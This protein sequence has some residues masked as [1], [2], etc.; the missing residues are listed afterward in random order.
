MVRD[1]HGNTAQVAPW[2]GRWMQLAIGI[3]CM[4]MIA[5]LQYGW[6]LFVEPIDDKHGWGRTAIQ[7]AFTIFIVTETWLV[8]VEGWFV[9]KFG[10]RI[11]VLVGGALC[12]LSW[13]LNAVADSLVLLYLAAVIGGIGAGGVYGTCVGNAL[14]WFPDRRGLAA[15]LTAAGF[16]A[17]S[18]LTVVP[19]ATM[20]ETSGFETTFMTFGLGQ[21]LVILVLAWFLVDPPKLGYGQARGGSAP[22]RRQYAP[23]EMLRTPVFWLM[24]GMF[25][26]VAAGGLM[27]TAQLGPIAADMGLV[28]APVSILGL[29]LPAL[30]FA[31]SIDRVMNGITRPFFGWVSDHI[32]R[33]NTMFIAF[34]IEAVGVM[35]LS[36]YGA[37][38]VAFVIL[39]GLVFFAWGEIFS[40]F[41]ACCGDT[42]GSRFA[43]TNAGLLYTAKG[44]AAL[45]VPVGNL[46]VEA[47][48]S[49]QTV[50]YSVAI[51]NALAAFLALFVLK[52]LRARY[53]AAA[54]STAPRLTTRLAD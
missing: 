18:A 32:G 47:T 28:D 44:V 29:T 49:W 3:V 23:Q 20:I 25:T 31:L 7:V 24:Y 54:S 41:P 10:P 21:G 13:A 19:I 34:T 2:G 17:G 27:V 37:D 53:V 26:M 30:T 46:M 12:A 45:L 9:D 22:Q 40:L 35:A 14:K 1:A 33:E 42:F 43:A 16:G 6:T 52:P 5:N 4:S 51:V 48:G 50:F 36:A 38:P 11:V 8:P 15:G 39:T